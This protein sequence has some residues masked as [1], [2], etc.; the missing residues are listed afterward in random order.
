MVKFAKNFVKDESGA[1]L[2]EYVLL[3]AL[4]GIAAIAGMTLVGTE[5]Q[6]TLTSVAGDLATGP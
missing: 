2:I 3:A 4:V 1:A 6:N 5:A